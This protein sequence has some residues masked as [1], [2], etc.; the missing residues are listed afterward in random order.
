MAQ[1]GSAARRVVSGVRTTPL[2]ATASIT[3]SPSI[4]ATC[5]HSDQHPVRMIQLN[6]LLRRVQNSRF[7]VPMSEPSRYRSDIGDGRVGSALRIDCI[8]S[9]GHSPLTK[10]SC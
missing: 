5:D 1:R 3:L 9:S 2:S 4:N 7:I 6:G 10:Q 8:G